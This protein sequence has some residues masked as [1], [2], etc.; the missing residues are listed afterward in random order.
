M[1]D[2]GARTAGALV[3]SEAIKA[4]LAKKQRQQNA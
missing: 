4:L 2:T 1:N 3:W